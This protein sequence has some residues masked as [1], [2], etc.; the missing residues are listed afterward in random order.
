MRQLQLDEPALRALLQSASP[1][2]VHHAQ[3]HVSALGISRRSFLGGA[4]GAAGAIA[5]ASLL[6]PLTGLAKQ[7]FN[8]TPR[9]TDT[10]HTIGGVDFHLTFFGPGLDPSSIA[11]FN[12]FTGVADVQGTG[13]ATNPDQSTETLL[14]DTDMRFMKGVYVGLDGAVHKG[15]FGFV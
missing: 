3:A 6:H 13:T 1:R 2:H 4:A 15:A 14:F 7:P 9:P 8:A 12:G 11:D 5:G 10:I